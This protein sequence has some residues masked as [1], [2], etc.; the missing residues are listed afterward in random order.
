MRLFWRL[1]AEVYPGLFNGSEKLNAIELT[2]RMAWRYGGVA[3]SLG[4][5]LGQEDDTNYDNL[6]RFP[7]LSSIAAARFTCEDFKKGGQKTRKYW[8]CLNTLINQ[9]LP[10][11]ADTFASRTHGRPY[12][13]PKVDRQINPENRNGQNFNGVMFSSKWLADDMNCNAQETATLRSLVEEAHKKAKFG[14]GSPADWWVIVLGDGDGMGKYVSGSKLKKYK[15]Y[16]ITDAIT[17][18]VK[19]HQDYPD[20]LA[21]QKRMGPATHVGLNRALLDFSNRLVPYLT[22]ERYCGKVVYS[23]GDDVMAV[24]PLAD[25]LGYLRSLRAAWCADPDP[26]REFSTEGGY[27]TPKQ[28]LQ[29][30]QQRPYFTMGDGATMSLGIVIAHK[31]VPLPTVLESLWTAEKDR[32]KKLYG[33]DG[34]CFRVIYGSGNTLEALMK[35]ELLDLWWNFMQYDQQD[36]SALF[37]RLAEEL[38]RHACVTESDRLFRKAAQVIINRRD[39]TLELLQINYML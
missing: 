1:M 37:Y 16:L 34:L 39:Q 17:E 10:N 30:L 6:I 29:G 4:I 32:A 12:Q 36:L 15:E 3:E 8:N 31:S 7:N 24:L 35:G 11:K 25:L 18:N 13:I 14:E 27:W 33:K 21:T 9:Q 19:N 38:P 23:G 5:N 26:E 2:K 20:L 28:S 22:E